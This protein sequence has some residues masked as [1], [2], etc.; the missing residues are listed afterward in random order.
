MQY[1]PPKSL[2]IGKDEILNQETLRNQGIQADDYVHYTGF[3]M[4]PT[5][6]DSEFLLIEKPA[7]EDIRVGD[8]IIYKSTLYEKLVIH[9]IIRKKGNLFTT[10]GDNNPGKDPLPVSFD[11]VYGRAIGILGK[12]KIHRVH[13]GRTGILWSYLLFFRA[14][15]KRHLLKPL[16][17]NPVTVKSRNL[18]TRWICIKPDLAFFKNS[19]GSL[20]VRLIWKKRYIGFYDITHKTL[21]VKRLYRVAI[22]R[23]TLHERILEVLKNETDL[24]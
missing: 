4:Y 6:H 12:D 11:A 13:N 17:W 7:F 20:R 24:T 18:L 10:K 1:E 16:I 21:F 8:I 19:D 9:R 23:R 5:F 2:N 3:S 22:N 14:L 15:I